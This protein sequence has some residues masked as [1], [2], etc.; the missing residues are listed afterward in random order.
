M[1]PKKRKNN[2]SPEIPRKE[3]KKNEDPPVLDRLVSLAI[4]YLTVR[5][6]K[7]DAHTYRIAKLD[8][9]TGLYMSVPDE[10]SKEEPSKVV[11]YIRL[12]L[13]KFLF[14]TGYRE[15][16]NLVNELQHLMTVN[17]IQT[18]TIEDCGDVDLIQN[19][20]MFAF[21]NNNI[22]N[23]KIIRTEFLSLH[24]DFWIKLANSNSIKTIKFDRFHTSRYTMEISK[25]CHALVNNKSITTVKLYEC[26]CFGSGV[27]FWN[28]FNENKIITKIRLKSSYFADLDIEQLSLG[29]KTNTILEYV[30]IS[31]IEGRFPPHFTEFLTD[32]KS[33][34]TIK[35]AGLNVDDIEAESISQVIT[36]NKVLQNIDLSANNFTNVG[37]RAICSALA[38]NNTILYVNLGNMSFDYDGLLE[39]LK[40]N[41]TIIS[42]N[43]RI[44]NS[45]E[46]YE[47]QQY[48]TRNRER[49]NQI[50]LENTLLALEWYKNWDNN[51]PNSNRPLGIHSIPP[52]LLRRTW[53]TILDTA[54][55]KE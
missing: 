20:C 52:H 21:E 41:T 10:D 44:N 2:N 31:Y 33:I 8:R 27:F 15:L 6:D 49:Y 37:I 12:Y 30:D 35:L 36:K 13:N 38:K 40:P 11:D 3:P 42:L 26:T 7:I 16:Q 14:D 9:N 50:R 29:I 5:Y 39:L 24:R 43:L 34:T 53:K 18:V 1:P 23:F 45:E 48:V 51:D 28:L 25:L 46:Y 4:P 47:L 17:K 32:N 55:D 19:F 22:V 54:A